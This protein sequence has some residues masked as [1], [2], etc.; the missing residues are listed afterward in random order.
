[1][2]KLREKC[3]IKKKITPHSMRRT[4]ATKLNHEGATTNDIMGAMGH[5]HV[6]T[7]IGYIK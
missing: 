5:S 1:M 7:T 6:Q 4:F 2:K 3:E